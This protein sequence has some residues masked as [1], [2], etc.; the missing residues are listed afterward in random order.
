MKGPQG[1]SSLAPVPLPPCRVWAAVS[2]ATRTR[3]LAL[4]YNGR[5]LLLAGV[6]P[7]G[8]AGAAAVPGPICQ[9]AM[10]S[11]KGN[12]LANLAV[13]PGVISGVALF[14]RCFRC[15]KAGSSSGSCLPPLPPSIRRGA[16]LACALA[17]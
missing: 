17:A 16:S 3:S 12:Y 4:F 10:K 2:S 9:A 15:G 14:N 13:F 6:A 5:C 7:A 11:G 8:A 1:H